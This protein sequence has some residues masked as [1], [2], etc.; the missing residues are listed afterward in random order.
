[1]DLC[2]FSSLCSLIFVSSSFLVFLVL[3]FVVPSLCVCRTEMSTFTSLHPYFFFPVTFSPFPPFPLTPCTVHFV[4]PALCYKLH[5]LFH[6]PAS[7]SVLIWFVLLVHSLLWC[8][9]YWLL[10]GGV[11]LMLIIDQPINLLFMVQWLMLSCIYVKKMQRYIIALTFF[12]VVPRSF[13][14]QGCRYIIMHY[15]VTSFGFHSLE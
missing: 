11:R 1:M 7:C 3:S 6:V 4:F 13:A 5:S 14:C 8:T 9:F 10:C 15:F 2:S 12:C